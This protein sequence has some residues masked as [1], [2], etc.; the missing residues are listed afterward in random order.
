MFSFFGGFRKPPKNVFYNTAESLC[1]LKGDA[2]DRGREFFIHVLARIRMRAK[3]LAFSRA[4]PA[5]SSEV[6]PPHLY[7]GNASSPGIS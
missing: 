5:A 2:L 1:L 4:V 7:V 6:P 3:T